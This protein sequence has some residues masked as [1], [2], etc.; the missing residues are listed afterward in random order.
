MERTCKICDFV[1]PYLAEAETAKARGFHGYVCW[2]CVIA[3]QR[4]WRQTALGREES[5]EITVAY[6]QRKAQR[7]KAPSVG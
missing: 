6:R 4:A 7:Q 3:E 5:R 2:G 1:G